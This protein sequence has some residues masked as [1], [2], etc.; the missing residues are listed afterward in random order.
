MARVKSTLAEPIKSGVVVVY[1]DDI[2]VKGKNWDDFLKNWFWVCDLL[3]AD[4]WKVGIVKRRCCTRRRS[5]FAV[6]Y[7]RL[8]VS[9]SIR[10]PSMR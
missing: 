9:S 5:S 1:M 4:D 8:K 6:E 7:L 3:M 2:I 10:T